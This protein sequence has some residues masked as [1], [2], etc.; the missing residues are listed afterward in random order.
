MLETVR[1]FGLE[2]LAESGEE[3]AVRRAHADWMIAFLEEAWTAI[4][5]RFESGWLARLD[6]ERDNVRSALGWLE[7][8]G[9]GEALLRLAGA[10]D[11][12]W[13]YHS[14][15]SEGRV[16][17]E[18]ALEQTREAAVSPAVRIR[19]LLAAGFLARNQG[20]H[21]QALAFGQECLELA[22][23]AND[24]AAASDSH[25]LLGY[26]TLAEGDYERARMHFEE[27]LRLDTALGDRERMAYAWL[28]LGRVRYG[29]GDYEHAAPLLEQ[30]LTML[31][32]VDDQ[33]HLALALNSLGLVDRLRGDGGNAA[34]RLLEALQLW[35]AFANKENLAEWLAIVATLAATAQAPQCSARLFG[36]AEALRAEIGHA[37]VLPDVHVFG[38]AERAIRVRL[39]EGA[40]QAEHAAG[41]ALP[42]DHAL[43]E[44]VAFLSGA[45][46]APAPRHPRWCGVAF[47]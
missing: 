26:V 27:Q 13:N 14:Y 39:E 19:A 4:M 32:D 42:L 11:P 17:L 29:Q 9:D 33:W 36:A 44:A 2:R 5:I 21:P 15:R 37:F 28:E 10:A 41:R 22:S 18:R 6:A 31:R 20:D 23:A 24:Q 8:V 16:W 12:L 7:T 40:F 35:R 25:H 3:P 47:V 30:A 46:A 34:D 38:E 1:E 43:E 45:P